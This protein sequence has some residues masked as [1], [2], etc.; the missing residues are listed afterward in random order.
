MPQLIT[1]GASGSGRQGTHISTEECSRNCTE[2]ASAGCLLQAP[3]PH[4]HQ[5]LNNRTSTLSVPSRR[6]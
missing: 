2:T 6:F 1:S 3:R 5:A 4:K